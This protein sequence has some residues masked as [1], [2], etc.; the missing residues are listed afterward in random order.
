MCALKELVVKGNKCDNDFKSGYL[1]LL[2]NMLAAKFPRTDLKG[3][4]HINSK[5][6]VWKRQYV[7][8]RNMLGISSVGLDS[9]SYHVEALPEV[10][11]S[12]L[13]VDPLTKSLRNKAFPLYS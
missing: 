10:W 9:T 4:P 8:L 3:E 1:L 2:E 6:H 13:K 11:E 12:Q 7:C 5:I